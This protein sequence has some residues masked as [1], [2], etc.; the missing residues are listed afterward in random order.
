[1]S[2]CLNNLIKVRFEDNSRI[3]IGS[4]ELIRPE[5]WGDVD[6]GGNVKYQDDGTQK[7]AFNVDLKET[8]PQICTVV[9]ANDK[10]PYGVGEKLFTHYMVVETCMDYDIVDMSGYIDASRVFFVINPDGSLRLAD[11]VF[12]G[13]AILI[14]E[15]VSQSG[16]IFGLGRKDR[17]RVRILYTHQN[18]GIDVGDIVMSIDAYNYEFTYEG[19]SYIMLRKDEIVCKV[20]EEV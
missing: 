9:I 3:R 8:R 5:V 14:G 2:K 13:E 10:F 1:M 4:L 17:L 16:I 12:I 18:S 20:L 11:K 19:K 7:M 15:E 6:E